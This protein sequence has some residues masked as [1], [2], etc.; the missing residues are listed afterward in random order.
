MPGYMAS[1]CTVSDTSGYSKNHDSLYEAYL[2]VV[3]TEIQAECC[4]FCKIFF[5]MEYS[6]PPS[7]YIWKKMK[8]YIYLVWD[9]V[10]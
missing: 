6:F 9:C 10:Y 8:P 5:F 7:S 4:E 1:F 3:K 2:A